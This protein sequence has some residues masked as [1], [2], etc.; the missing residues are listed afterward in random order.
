MEAVRTPEERFAA[1]ER[2]RINQRQDIREH[3]D[4]AVEGF[5]E[6]LALGGDK[7]VLFEA[8]LERQGEHFHRTRLGQELKDLAFVDSFHGGVLVGIAGTFRDFGVS[9]YL[10]QEKTLTPQKIRSAS[11]G[12]PGR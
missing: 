2:E 11:G 4:A 10:L 5:F 8:G 12:Q 3:L 6:Q 1:P 9:S 7:A